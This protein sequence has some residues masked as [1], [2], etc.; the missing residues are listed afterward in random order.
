LSRVYDL[1]VLTMLRQ[2]AGAHRE[3]HV[4]IRIRG[5]PTVAA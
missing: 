1:A 2:I 4:L 5:M 3:G